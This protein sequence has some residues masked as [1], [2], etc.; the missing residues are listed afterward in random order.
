[1][2][3]RLIAGWRISKGFSCAWL[4]VEILIAEV[5]S[6][7]D[8]IKIVFLMA[9]LPFNSYALLNR[10]VVCSVMLD[11]CPI[12]PVSTNCRFEFATGALYA[13]GNAGPRGDAILFDG[14]VSSSEKTLVIRR[15][16]WP[17]IPMKAI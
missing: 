5:M 15:F 6:S 1:M 12:F 9:M 10:E 16:R 2:L 4:A 13:A 8:R 7:K 14:E 17:D 11:G 3:V